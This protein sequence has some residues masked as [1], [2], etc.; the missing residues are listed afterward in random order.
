MRDDGRRLFALCWC[1]IEIDRATA[2]VTR[3]FFYY[4]LARLYGNGVG[5]S[6]AKVIKKALGYKVYAVSIHSVFKRVD[7]ERTWTWL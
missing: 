7:L 4:K 1:Q 6:L 5:R 3:F 2:K